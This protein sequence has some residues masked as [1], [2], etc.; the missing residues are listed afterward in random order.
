MVNVVVVSI[1]ASHTAVHQIDGCQA[2]G[3]DHLIFMGG[4]DVL[5]I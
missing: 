3:S 2:L 1:R 5:K 4:G